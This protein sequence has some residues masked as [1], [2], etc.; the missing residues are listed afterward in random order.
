MPSGSSGAT[1]GFGMPADPS[2]QTVAAVGMEVLVDRVD[3]RVDGQ[4]LLQATLAFLE[5][6]SASPRDWCRL[7]LA[8]RV[9]LSRGLPLPRATTLAASPAQLDLIELEPRLKLRRLTTLKLAPA[10]GLK[11]LLGFR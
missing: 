11:P 2:P 7:M 9:E 8:V 4:L 6:F 5:P 1:R 10:F 3:L